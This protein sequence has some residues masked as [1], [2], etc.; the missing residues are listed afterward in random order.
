MNM[1]RKP[2]GVR[3]AYR[4]EVKNR[5]P[6][7][8][9]RRACIYDA[10]H[11]THLEIV[12]LVGFAVGVKQASAD[13]KFGRSLRLSPSAKSCENLSIYTHHGELHELVGLIQHPLELT[14]DSSRVR[15]GQVSYF[16]LRDEHAEPLDADITYI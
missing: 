9:A 16:K 12:E 13:G 1:I 4:R 14:F 7:S 5:H 10:T 2:H 6:D 15:P 3:A 8:C 11:I